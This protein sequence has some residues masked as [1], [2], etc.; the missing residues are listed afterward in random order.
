MNSRR[1]VQKSSTDQ[2]L[3]IYILMF[4]WTFF[5][6]LGIYTGCRFTLISKEVLFATITSNEAL[7]FLIIS[8]CIIIFSSIVM[9]Q[10]FIR[11]GLLVPIGI[12]AIGYGYLIGISFV[13]WGNAA[14]LFHLLYYLPNTLLVIADLWFWIKLIQ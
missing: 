9:M 4:G 2:Y 13:T 10:R 11:W 5:L 3:N 12:R 7:L 6:S 8:R 14:W 1:K